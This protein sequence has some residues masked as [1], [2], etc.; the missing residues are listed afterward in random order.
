ML[1]LLLTGSGVKAWGQTTTYTFSSNA[2]AASPANWTSI[3]NGNA[4]TSGQGIQVTTGATGACGNSPISFDNVTSVKVGYTTNSDKGAG[5]INVFSVAGSTATAQSGTRIGSSTAVSTSGGTTVRYLTFN[6]SAISGNIQIYVTCTTNSIYINSVEITYAA[7]TPDIALADNDPQVAAADVSQ[8]TAAVVLHKFQLGVSSASALL[9]GMTCTTTGTYAAADITNLK[10]RYSTDATLDGADATLSTF[11]NPGAAGSKTFPSFTSRSIASG[12]TGYIFIT[13]DVAATAT[14]NNT[15]AVDAITTGNLTF[16]SGNKTGST[17]A[18]GAQTFKDVTAPTVTTYSPLDGNTAVTINQNLVLTF[19][20]AVKAGTAGDIVIYN[21]AGAFETIPYN[22]SRIT[23][24]SNTVTINPNGTFAYGANYYVQVAGTAITDNVGNAYAGIANN[25]TWNFTTVAP[26]VTNVTSTNADGTYKV[27]DVI[28]VTVTFND[29]VVVTGTPYILLKMVGTNRQAA[30]ALGS[31]TNTLTFS[32]TLQDT[33]AASDLDYV[34]TNSLYV[35]SGTI[36]SADGVAVTRTLA[37]PG[38]AGS[39]GYNKDIVVDCVKP[40]VSSYNPTDGNTAVTINQN[41]VLTFNENVKRGA[42]GSIV[43]YTTGATVFETIPYDDS[44][45]AFSSNTVTINPE[46]TFAYSSDYYVQTTGN[47]ISDMYDNNYAGISNATTWNFTT[48]CGPVTLPFSQDFTTYLPNTC[49]TEK[50]GL[51]A[52]PSTLTEANSA[53]TADGFANNGTTGSARLN[54]YGTTAKE[55]LITPTIDLGTTTDYQLEFDLALTD[56]GNANA[57]TTDANGTTGTD[58]KFAVVISTDNGATWTSANTLRIWNNSG[59]SD[60]YNNLTPAGTHVTISLADYTGWVKIGFY[61]ESTVSNADNDLFIDNLSVVQ[62][63]TCI[64]P[65]VVTSSDVTAIS[66]TIS[67]V[68]SSSNPANGYQYELRTSGA[69]GSGATGLVTS[70]TTAAGVVSKAITDLVPNTTYNVFVR[71]DCGAGDN[72]A[73]TSVYSFSTPNLAA[74]TATAATAIS[75]TGFTANWGAVSGASNYDINVYQKTNIGKPELVNNGTFETADL[76]NWSFETSMN[77]SVSALQKK[78]GINSLYSTVSATKNMSQT[79]SVTS[80]AEYSLS[81][82][83]YIDATSSGNGFR[84]WTTDGATLQLPTSSSYYNDKGAWVN[85][86][87]NFTATSNSLVLNIR[88][89]NG[90]K[91]YLDDISVKPISDIINNSPVPGS[92]F[93]LT[94][95]SKTV[96]GLNPGTEYF[97]TVVSKNASGSSAASNEISVTT[98]KITF[99]GTGEWT[100]AARWNTGVVPGTTAEVVVDGAA[101]INSDVEVAGLTINA[102]KS[103]TV[104]PAKQLTITGTATNNGTI[105][106]QSDANGTGTIVGNVSGNATVNQYLKGDYRTWYLSSPVANA[107]PANLGWIKYYNEADGGWPTLFD[108]RTSS[109]VAYGSNS[110]VTAKG[111]LVV[112]STSAVA[113]ANIQFVGELNTGN[114][115]IALTNSVVTNTSK[116]G[117]NLVGNPYPS[118]LKWADVYAANSSKLSSASI[119]YRTKQ[120]NELSQLEYVFWTVN[121]D[122]VVTPLGVSASSNIPPMQAFWVKTTAGG[123]TLELT[124]NMRS[125]ANATGFLLKAPAVDTRTLIRLQVSNGTNTDEAVLYLSDNANNGLDAF[126]APKMTNDN[127]SIAEIFTRAGN[128]KLVINALQSLPKD[129]E[130]ALGF[131][132]G[133]ATTFTLR[134]NE[135]SNLPSDVK[136]IL[137][138]NVTKAETD[139]TDGTAV[140]SFNNIATSGDRFS[141]IFRTKGA[142]TGIDQP[143]FSGLSAYSNANNQLTVL[144]DGAI[145]AQTVV[146]VYNAVGQRLVTQSLK[147]VSTVID[148]EFAPGVYVVKV[149]N[150]SR[151]LT[152]KK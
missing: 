145:D 77:Q 51:L 52:A 35:G 42:S 129:T 123:G 71:S 95:T 54:I 132:A 112:P 101:T 146:S 85:V 105:T 58:D 73:W 55:W 137:K 49:W 100:D 38:A 120:L 151:K 115:S 23:F 28:T 116:P 118:Y 36:N 15:I 106:I 119:W 72:S 152:I 7:G 10:V 65:T 111:Y 97:Y 87:S 70:G 99:T 102:G 56:Y 74:P 90:V 26:S 46:G 130:I 29:N 3:K 30:Y 124:N 88:L 60:V 12:A 75:T 79:I 139:L 143:T 41:L 62:L 16:S 144:Y 133:S 134:V 66:A 33:D 20:E 78:S 19:S 39:L 92:P 48:E 8:G 136:L 83:Y 5:T 84:I 13:A 98:P 103:L 57:I 117:F 80:G 142:V 82:W 14:H 108:A 121:G 40:T 122:G 114:K 104:N 125:H 24:S 59:S 89:Y 2:W 86:Q 53:W 96:S 37:S 44:R 45:I 91:L 27:G 149:N 18:G 93:T 1:A 50:T 107:Q 128:E 69:A 81:F 127:A 9:T 63:A 11:T 22:D 64:T 6:T 141:I 150:L 43:I 21:S 25:T 110:F 94:E 126:D 4:F 147:G 148:G 135:L 68:A 131:E 76:S 17:T 140:Y 61:G 109:A 113:N 67:W 47:P 32:Y 138:D 34:A 31:G